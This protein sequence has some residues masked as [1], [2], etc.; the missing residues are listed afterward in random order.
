VTLLAF[1][2]LPR[3]ARRLYGLPATLVGDLWA[4]TTLKALHTGLGLIPAQV[5]YSPAAR[6]ARRLMAA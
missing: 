3:W 5:R 6:L 1:A 2:T 4:T